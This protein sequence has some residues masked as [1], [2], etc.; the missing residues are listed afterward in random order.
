M[1]RQSQST[2]YP[3]SSPVGKT[4]REVVE[5]LPSGPLNL[6][7]LLPRQWSQVL[8]G[9]RVDVG[10]IRGVDVTS[11]ICVKAHR[12]YSEFVFICVPVQPDGTVDPRW[13][14][15]DRLAVAEVTRSEIR[16]WDEFQVDWSI[17][18]D[19]GSSARHHARVGRFLLDHHVEAVV[20]H[21]VGDGMIRQL[22]VM[23]VALHLGAE[24]DARSAVLMTAADRK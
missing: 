7:A 8:Y 5:A 11:A 2:C 24:G 23:K 4:G 3:V 13:G 1:C 20:A 18:H 15:A 9:R 14:N 19:E 22:G 10:A 12:K 21:H 16:S 17:R 6:D